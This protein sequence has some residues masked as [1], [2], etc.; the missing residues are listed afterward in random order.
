MPM[1]RS[2]RRSRSTSWMS[3][4]CQTTT[5]E[6]RISISESSPNPAS[7][8]ERATT[9]AARTT[10]DPTT[11]QP[12]VAYSRPRPRRRSCSAR[13]TG[14]RLGGTA[15]LT[16]AA[17]T[18]RWLL[19]TV[20]TGGSS[21]LRVHAWRKLRSLGALYLQS[22]VALLP[23]RAETRRAI[24]RLLE[25]LRRS[26][27]EGQ[28]LPIAITDPTAE[29]TVI[30]RFCAERSDEYSEIVSRV[31]AFLEE[32]AQERRQGRAT[33]AEVEESEADLERLQ[34]WLT[35]VQARD[36]FDARGRT[37]AEQAV[38]GCASELVAFEAEALA[39]ELPGDLGESRST[40][41]PAVEGESAR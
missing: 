30:A 21:T 41:L 31:P 35:R 4:S 19:V 3:W 23:D 11:F 24:G 26:G 37:E 20:S 10:P 13:S 38:E 15:T 29:Q 36:Y 25:R 27:G 16:G 14:L 34:K 2:A 33:Y 6:A 9:A 1:I 18:K 7:A 17:S 12:S 28:V 40:R 5:S 39:A 22:S 8:T 32:I